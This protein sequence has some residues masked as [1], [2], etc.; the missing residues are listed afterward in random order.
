MEE[1]QEIQLGG[2]KMRTIDSRG[3]D[4][5]N[6][7]GLVIRDQ[8][9]ETFEDLGHVFQ[10]GSHI[11]TGHARYSE[12]FQPVHDPPPPVEVSW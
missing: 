12:F 1:T 4:I 8:R 7:E 2:S 11:G 9:A 10:V 3:L 6:G 5:V